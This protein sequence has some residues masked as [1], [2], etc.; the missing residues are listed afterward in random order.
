MLF[1]VL[2]CYKTLEK[3]A[4]QNIPAMFKLSV[5]ASSVVLS[6]SV[7]VKEVTGI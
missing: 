3:Y 7:L 4:W 5:I 1:E 2:W 6:K